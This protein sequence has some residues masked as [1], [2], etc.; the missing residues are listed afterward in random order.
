MPLAQMACEVLNTADGRGKTALSRRFAAEWFAKRNAELPVEVGLAIPPN[1]PAR[2]NAPELLAPR[3]VPRRKTGSEAGRNALLHAVAHIELNAVDLHWDLIARFC[4]TPMPI[5]YYDDWVK[6]ADEESKHFNMM[7]DCLESHSSFYGAMPAHVGMWRAAED[8]AND[9]L[10][11]LPVVPMVL[12][13]RGLDVTPGMIKIFEAAKDQ[14]VVDALNVIY[15]EEVAHVAYGSKWFHYLCGRNE[16]DPK[17]KFHE[18][19][20]KYFHGSLKPPFNEEKRAEAGIA[21]D[22]YWPLANEMQPPA[23]R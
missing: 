11:R 5:G 2:P 7:C 8:T 3:D 15:S 23:M 13:A 9:F 1:R 16:I 22:F 12:E 14:Q 10:G 4:N 18:L 17:P 21:P 6:A 19:V 20:R